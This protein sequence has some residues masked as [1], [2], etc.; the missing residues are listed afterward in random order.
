MTSEPGRIPAYNS[1]GTLRLRCRRYSLARYPAILR[2]GYV[3]R[4]G[5]GYGHPPR[6][7][8]LRTQPTV[9]NA[10]PGDGVPGNNQAIN[11]Q[12]VVAALADVT[13]AKNHAGTLTPGSDV[14]YNLVVSNAGPDAAA[15]V[16]VTDTLAAGLTFKSSSTGCTAAVPVVTCNIRECRHGHAANRDVHRDHRRSGSGGHSD[17]KHRQRDDD[18][19]RNL[20][21]ATTAPTRIPS[22]LGRRRSISALAITVTPTTAAPGDTVTYTVTV[23]NPDTATDATNVVVTDVL[24][25]GLTAVT[26]PTADLTGSHGRPSQATRGHGPSRRSPRPR[27]R[28]LRRL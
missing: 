13:I 24:P 18:H 10:V 6:R 4:S 15:V 26:P 17:N 25:A 3:D 22:P 2:W 11:T 9:A 1:G 20:M 19:S 16:V 28:R 23:T 27:R 5:D 14:T 21:A 8:R 12:T 7:A